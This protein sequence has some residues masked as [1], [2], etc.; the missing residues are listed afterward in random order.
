MNLGELEKLVLNYFWTQSSADAKQVHLHFSR[1]RGGTLNTIQSTLDRLY[2]KKLL[3][4]EKRG[5][6][7][8]YSAG[9]TRSEFI[10]RLVRSVTEDFVQ[11]GEDDLLAAFVSLTTDLKEPQLSKLEA[12]IREYEASHA[13]AENSA[14]EGKP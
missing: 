1:Q 9:C 4:R 13:S 8:V 12:T 3:R 14:S 5:H 7:Y 6:A 11:P 10:G 2:K